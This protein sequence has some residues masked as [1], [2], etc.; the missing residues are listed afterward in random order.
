MRRCPSRTA[1]WRVAVHD[2]LIIGAGPAGATAARLLAGAGWSVAL[3][4]K[5]E[6]PR[7]KVCGEFISATSLPLLHD[8]RIR[9]E[10]LRQAGPEI[11][12]VGL[13]AKSAVLS[14]RMPAMAGPAGG[15]GRALGRDRLDLLLTDAA[16]K[17]GAVLWQPWKVVALER[18]GTHF[19]CTIASGEVRQQITARFVIAANGSWEKSPWL[20]DAAAHERSDL[21]AFK[22]HFRNARLASELMPLIAFPGGYGGI[23]HSDAGRVSLSCC[24]RRDV[25]ESCRQTHRGMPA[26]DAV[27]RHISRHCDGVRESLGDTE[28]EGAWLAAGPIRPGIR[29]RYAEGVFYVGNA[30]GEAHPIVAEGISMA[31][32]SAWLLCNRLLRTQDRAASLDTRAQAGRL[33][34]RDWRAAFALRIYAAA[35]FAHTAMWPGAERLLPVIERF[36]KILSWGATLSGKTALLVR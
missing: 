36:P 23:V 3:V 34:A 5:A 33:Y 1:S 6:F 9:D 25:L 24:I 7:R 15:W 8:E 31:M 30:A 35:A 16:V 21:L 17:A 4:E 27:M 20:R 18:N 14:T 29:P 28:V 2:A 13:F 10:F 26:G 19:V 12:R 11:R 22:A 32:Q